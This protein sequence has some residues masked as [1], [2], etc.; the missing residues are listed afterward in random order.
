MEA[1]FV[2]V[3]GGSAGSVLANRLSED[4]RNRVVLVEAG[5]DGRGFLLSMPAGYG[6][7][8]NS[9]GHSWHYHGDEEPSINKRRMLLP[10][11]KGLGGS[12]ARIHSWVKA[13][14]VGEGPIF[15]KHDFNSDREDFFII[16]PWAVKIDCFP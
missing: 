2:I 7:T 5:A 11:G 12:S 13:S 14:S 1:D 16:K 6:V 15:R 8:A 3:G 9:P 10:R 4:P